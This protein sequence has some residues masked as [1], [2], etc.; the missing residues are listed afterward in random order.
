ME[1]EKEDPTPFGEVMNRACDNL[2]EDW[3][4]R[5]SYRHEEAAIDLID[6]EG[7]EVEVCDDD[8]NVVQM[9]ERRVDHARVT[10]GLQPVFDDEYRP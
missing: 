7:D 3:E 6:P 8:L 10:D 2:P 9:V 5:V 1:P 4:I